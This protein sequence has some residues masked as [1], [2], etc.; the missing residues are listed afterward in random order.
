MLENDT[1]EVL[2]VLRQSSNHSLLTLDTRPQRKKTKSRFIFENR[3]TAYQVCETLVKEAWAT[4]FSGSRMYQVCQKLKGC[5]F[6]FLQWRK[7][8]K[9]NARQEVEMLQQEMENM[10]LLGGDRD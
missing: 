4:S 2:H 1:A 8:Q 5:K 3:W 6:K 10:Q 7:A 9:H